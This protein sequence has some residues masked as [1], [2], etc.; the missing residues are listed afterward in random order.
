MRWVISDASHTSQHQPPKCGFQ[1]QPLE[2]SPSSPPSCPV[3][4]RYDETVERCVRRGGADSLEEMP[5][6][7]FTRR[8]MPSFMYLHPRIIAPVH[9]RLAPLERHQRVVTADDVESGQGR[10]EGEVVFERRGGG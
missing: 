8:E 1:L 3:E 9:E 2:Y 10:R 5:P 7:G 6:A 4:E